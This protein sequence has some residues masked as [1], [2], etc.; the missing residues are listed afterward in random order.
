[1]KMPGMAGLLRA[2]LFM[3]MVSLGFVLISCGGGGG[4]ETASSVEESGDLESL[5]SDASMKSQPHYQSLEILP[6][7]YVQDAG[8]P[9][10][11]AIKGDAQI[12]YSPYTGNV[13]PD[14]SEYEI[15][16]YESSF[17]LIDVANDSK[18]TLSNCYL[19]TELEDGEYRLGIYNPADPSE[20]L[21]EDTPVLID[22]KTLEIGVT[23]DYHSSFESGS[24]SVLAKEHVTIN[25]K[26]Y[27]AWKISETS[28]DDAFIVQ[29]TRW[30]N[31]KYGILKMEIKMINKKD[32]SV[33]FLD[34]ILK[35]YH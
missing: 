35:G 20:I 19:V 12:I 3:I 28:E 7:S 2:G 1:M 27:P 34:G 30:V 25:N 26:K 32:D 24:I 31:P 33:M 4:G 21:W 17:H 22:F 15:Y 10:K 9:V 8:D 14:Y 11:Q 18:A 23:H 29:E 13:S 16:Q 5:S 6:T